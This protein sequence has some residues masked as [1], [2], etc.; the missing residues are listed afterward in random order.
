MSQITLA[1]IGGGAAVE[2]FEDELKK[3]VENILDPNTE[4]NAKRTIVLTVTIKPTK[5]RTHGPVTV[6]AVSK[7]AP[8]MTYGTVAYFGMDGETPVAFEDNPKQVTI[9]DFIANKQETPS[10]APAK[11]EAQS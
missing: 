1:N 2:K 6:S 10:I 3:V 8:T 5:D 7:L 4:P 9:G 11:E